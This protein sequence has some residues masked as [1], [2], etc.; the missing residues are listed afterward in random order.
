MEKFEPAQIKISFSNAFGKI[1]D[2][3][4]KLYYPLPSRKDKIVSSFIEL[5]LSTMMY[6][7]KKMAM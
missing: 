6:S 3:A 5:I 2:T 4:T 7:H 1:G